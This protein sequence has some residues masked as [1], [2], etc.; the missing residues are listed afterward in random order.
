MRHRWAGSCVAKT[1]GCLGGQRASGSRASV[2]PAL[3]SGKFLK[4]GRRKLILLPV[5]EAGCGFKCLPQGL[6][7]GGDSRMDGT[8]TRSG[9]ST[10]TVV[11]CA[12]RSRSAAGACRPAA[13]TGSSAV[14][15]CAVCSSAACPRLALVGAILASLHRQRTVGYDDG[16]APG[17]ANKLDEAGHGGRGRCFRDQERVSC[18]RVLLVLHVLRAGDD[19][20]E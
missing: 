1:P 11:I 15:P 13:A 5:R 20:I 2:L 8:K 10:P 16:R 12:E 4:D 6:R 3:V 18:Q 17:T 19:A 9:S 14:W 7:H